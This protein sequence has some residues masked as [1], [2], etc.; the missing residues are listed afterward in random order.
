MLGYVLFYYSY[1]FGSTDQWLGGIEY[2]MND[3]ALGNGKSVISASL[4][5]GLIE[6]I[7]DSVV[8][9]HEAGIVVVAA[10]GNSDN[11][12]CTSSPGRAPLAITVGKQLK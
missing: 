2:V 1:G 4:G 7:D 10:A 8:A 3:H 6:A 12:A 11:D 5:Y 9:A